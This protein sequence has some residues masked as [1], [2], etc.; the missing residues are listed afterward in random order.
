[1]KKFL[2]ILF[3]FINLLSSGT[4]YYIKPGGNNYLDGQSI[5]NAWATIA[6]VNSYS[7]SPGFNAGDIILFEKGGVWN[8]RLSFASSGSVG[9]VITIGAYGSG[10][11]P[12]ISGFFNITTGWV[13]YGSGIYSRSLTVG[14]TP[15][16]VLFDGENIPIGRYPNTGFLTIDNSSSTSITDAALPASPS[17]TGAEAAI[18]TAGWV[19]ERRTITHSSHTITFS[20]VTYPTYMVAN[21]GYIIQN[22]I[23][24]LD[25]LGEWCYIGGTFY[26]YFGANNPVDYTVKVSVLD[27]LLTMGSK[28]YVTI[29]NITFEGANIAAVYLSGSDYI[30]IQACAIQNNGK[31]GIQDAGGSDY[32]TIS[33]NTISNCNDI[34]IITRSSTYTTIVGND[35]T[36]SGFIW[37]MGGS[38][39]RSYSG[40]DQNGGYSGGDNALITLNKILNCGYDG[41]AFGGQNT[42]VSYNFIDTHNLHKNDG[43]G[44]YTYRDFSTGKVVKYNI[45]INGYGNTESYWA[46]STDEKNAQGLYNDG[47][48]YVT[49]DHNICAFNNGNGLYINACNHITAT[50]NTLFGNQSQ[51]LVMSEA[52]PYRASN[53]VINNNIYIAKTY[54][55]DWIESAFKIV[56]QYN[57]LTDFVN[58]G[59]SDYNYFIRP[60]STDATYIDT[61]FGAWEWK[62]NNRVGYNL[63]GWKAIST[64]NDT[65]SSSTPVIVASSNYVNLLYNETGINKSW[66]ITGT[67]VDHTGAAVTGTVTLTPYTSKV[68]IGTGVATPISGGTTIP[69]LSTSS[70]SDITATTATGG[71]N[72]TSDGGVSI[73]A[74]GVCWN[75]TLNPTI[76]NS[77]TSDGTGTGSYISYITGLIDGTTYYIRAY[78]TNAVGTAYG[79]QRAFISEAGSKGDMGVLIKQLNHFIKIGTELIKY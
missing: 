68:I 48:I 34:S 59:V 4:T 32:L 64:G 69:T 37:G 39:D 43:G 42:E 49:Y 70:I 71:G 73:T 54:D 7:L 77:H 24:C 40:I 11:N 55:N 61:W 36:N 3:L 33:G 35:I 13:P 27:Y 21:N 75:T 1:M 56:T 31:Y 66:I 25:Q 18:R 79:N 65:H 29:E 6:R 51:L 47:S 12:V 17:F 50:Y 14:S 46:K 76:V 5:A 19:I 60:V 58:F 8:E 15:N 52:A 45:V 26:M 10:V 62:Y 72:I 63:A 41:I 23:D 78:A 67:L 22:D 74:R 57:D 20:A 16:I 44:T 30:T 2:I 38:T 9:N 28:N 53:H